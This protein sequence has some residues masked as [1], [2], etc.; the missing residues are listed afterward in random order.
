MTN[1][2][3]GLVHLPCW[4]NWRIINSWTFSWSLVIGFNHV[5]GF[6]IATSWIYKSCPRAWL[7]WIFLRLDAWLCSFDN[8]DFRACKSRRLCSCPIVLRAR[9]LLTIGSTISIITSIH[10]C[11]VFLYFI[12]VVQGCLRHYCLWWILT[13]LCYCVFRGWGRTVWWRDLRALRRFGTS[14]NH[15]EGITRGPTGRTSFVNG[16]VDH[17]FMLVTDVFNY[18]S[19]LF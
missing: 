2:F 11:H 12:K 13:L 4:S 6:V 10:R 5:F 14:S 18:F 3:L 17:L 16:G 7:R 15:H 1:Y 8:K 9:W 19:L